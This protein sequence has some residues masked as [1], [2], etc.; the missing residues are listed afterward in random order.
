MS[1]D[2]ANFSLPISGSDG[3]GILSLLH[4]VDVIENHNRIKFYS[5]YLSGEN[6][7]DYHVCVTPNKV[8]LNKCS[9]SKWYMGSNLSEMSR[10]EIQLAIERLSDSLHLSMDRADVTRF[11]VA[12]NIMLRYPVEVYFAFMGSLSRFERL[13]QP[14]ALYYKQ[15]CR[16][17]VMYDKV[18]E[19]KKHGIFL[20][21]LYRS[22]NLMRMEMRYKKPR[23]YFG[24]VTGSTLYDSV[25]YCKTINEL[26]EFY[27]KVE[28]LN[29]QIPDFSN[30]KGLKGLQKLG[31]LCLVKE[32]GGDVEFGNRL[33]EAQL[34]GEITNKEVYDIRK[35]VR[36]A[37]GSKSMR[38]NEAVIELDKKVKQIK[39]R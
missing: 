36:S 30:V 11:D 22:A 25:F 6:G 5:G 26:I 31:L 37:I 35:A 14:H 1:V 16:E 9:L 38:P 17:F 10:S 3:D 12:K 7:F 32:W 19:S 18:M 33:K 4:D 8:L 15:A 2:T 23:Q 13:S 27:L 28:K 34:R 21:E 39:A 24:K 20:P 29:K